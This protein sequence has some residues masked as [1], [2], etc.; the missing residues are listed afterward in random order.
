MARNSTTWKMGRSPN[1]GG[2]PAKTLDLI[3]VERLAR[4]ASPMAIERLTYWMMSNDPSA[5]VRACQIIL[6]RAWGRPAQTVAHSGHIGR[7]VS[8]LTD[9]ELMAIIEGGRGLH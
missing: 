1:P 7:G 4:E 6:D 8:E 5:S 3:E 9:A 2:W